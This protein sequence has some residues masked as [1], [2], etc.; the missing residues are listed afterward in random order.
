MVGE[1]SRP[2]TKLDCSDEKKCASGIFFYISGDLIIR[3]ALNSFSRLQQ[4]YLPI[5]LS[6]R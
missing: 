1:P 2:R 3:G 6:T 4:F 5:S